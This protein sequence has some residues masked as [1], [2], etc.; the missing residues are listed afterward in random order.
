MQQPPSG[1]TFTRMISSCARIPLM[2]TFS[3]AGAD[4]AGI[5][6]T[7]YSASV[8]DAAAC[9]AKKSDP[10]TATNNAARSCARKTH[11]P[12]ADAEPASRITIGIIVKRLKIVSV[13]RR[14]TPPKR[15]TLTIDTD[16]Y[17]TCGK[18]TTF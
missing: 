13:R 9:C 3:P 8:D 16:G 17:V 5:S 10:I 14:L 18:C 4:D 7:T 2:K 12:T 15:L 11:D 1:R 6:L